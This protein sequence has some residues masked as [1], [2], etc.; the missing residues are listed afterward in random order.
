MCDEGYSS[1]QIDAYFNIAGPAM[2][3]K[4]H[5]EKAGGRFKPCN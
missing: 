1:E 4:T 3:T 5:G 2:L